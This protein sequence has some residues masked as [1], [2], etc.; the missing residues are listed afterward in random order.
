M[1]ISN[2]QFLISKKFF[3]LFLFVFFVWNNT[4]LL[5]VFA[6]SVTEKSTPVEVSPT[7]S[8]E[9]VELESFK[10]KIATKVAEL[11][12]KNLKA[13]SGEVLTIDTTS[14]S[15]KIKSDSEEEFEVR[16]DN[17]LTKYY[18]ISNNQKFEIDE[19]KV[20]VGTYI[21]A[22]GIIKEKIIEANFIYI[23]ETFIVATGKIFEVN[24]DDYYISIISSD[25]ENYTLDIE[26]KTKQTI[27]SRKISHK[28]K[29]ISN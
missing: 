23:D 24:S 15:I 12:E 3:F 16:V 10:E 5:N 28:I 18:Q 13:V 7:K 17:D 9:E 26:K 11:R 6:Q 25:K 22:T 27:L 4:L 14:G 19:S 20:G 8:Q 1:K 2:F 29:R 21:I